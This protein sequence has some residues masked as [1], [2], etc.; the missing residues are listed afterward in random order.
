METGLSEREALKQA[1]PIFDSVP[2]SRN[3]KADIKK[4]PNIFNA[5]LQ[6]VQATAS[7]LAR[8]NRSITTY[9]EMNLLHE[10]HKYILL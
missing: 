7:K 1:Q 2:K 9:S 4:L 3:G 5:K 8:T 10:E 6:K